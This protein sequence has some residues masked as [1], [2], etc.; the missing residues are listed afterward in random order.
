MKFRCKLVI[1]GKNVSVF[2][3]LGFGL[4]GEDSLGGFSTGQ[5][6]QR[7]HQLPLWDVRLLLDLLKSEEDKPAVRKQ[8]SS[9]VLRTQVESWETGNA[10]KTGQY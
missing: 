4:L 3:F 1:D 10:E 5:R 9:G 6:L 2:N 8:R 7:S